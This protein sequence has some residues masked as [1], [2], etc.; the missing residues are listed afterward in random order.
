MRLPFQKFHVKQPRYGF[1][2]TCTVQQKA[3]TCHNFLFISVYV[4]MYHIMNVAIVRPLCYQHVGTYV[5]FKKKT[6]S[7]SKNWIS[8]RKR[9]GLKLISA[10]GH[11]DSVL[12]YLAPV[13]CFPFN[14]N[15]MYLKC[16]LNYQPQTSDDSIEQQA[17]S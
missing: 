12:K 6:K 17:H 15:H 11:V 9:C 14:S 2:P 8:S 5:A 13:S 1:S 4:Y 10:T 7:K 3:Q 16:Q